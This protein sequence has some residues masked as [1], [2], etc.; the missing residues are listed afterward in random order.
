MPFVTL[1]GFRLTAQFAG[2]ILV[3]GQI[4][5]AGTAVL[6]QQG[7]FAVV[8]LQ[9]LS[10]VDQEGVRRIAVIGQR[11]VHTANQI[12]TQY[13]FIVSS[14]IS[15][16]GIGLVFLQRN[17]L[18]NAVVAGQD[19]HLGTVHLKHVDNLT[20]G[21]IAVVQNNLSF[22]ST[23]YQAVVLLGNDVIVATG[24]IGIEPA[25]S[26]GNA[27]GRSS[28]LIDG[29]SQFHEEGNFF[30]IFCLQSCLLFLSQCVSGIHGIAEA[31]Q[32][33]N[34]ILHAHL[35]E[36]AFKQDP[37][38]TLVVTVVLFYQGIKECLHLCLR[39]FGRLLVFFCYHTCR[40]RVC[41]HA[42]LTIS[43]SLVS[44]CSHRQN[45]QRHA[46]TEQ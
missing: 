11:N 30:G 38:F 37:A 26:A 15:D 36:H 14:S 43:G 42:N 10:L 6:V 3:N 46:N 31:I 17:I 18:V 12:I 35:C 27:H 9:N 41:V 23:G 16:L 7:V 2:T 29:S 24:N 45:A 8:I 21:S 33:C 1:Q 32:I 25:A 34:H 13:I 20:A 39:L 19:I 22:L 44:K 4:S 5:L 28:L 40:F